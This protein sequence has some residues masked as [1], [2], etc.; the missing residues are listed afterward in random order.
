MSENAL[1]LT[2]S[3]A[4]LKIFCGGYTREPPLTRG[5]E[6]RR[7]GWERKGRREGE[8]GRRVKDEG[9]G[10]TVKAEA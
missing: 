3:N 5:V 9:K 6:G 10:G 4:E 2:Y 7:G 8:T 1:K